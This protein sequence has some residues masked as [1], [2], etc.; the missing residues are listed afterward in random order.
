MK[1]EE[2]DDKKEMKKS[3]ATAA[4]EKEPLLSSGSLPRNR[5]PRAQLKPELDKGKSI[6]RDFTPEND[7]EYEDD[8]KSNTDVQQ[9]YREPLDPTSKKTS[10]T[11]R[12]EHSM[13]S[14]EERSRSPN[15]VEQIEQDLAIDE[16]YQKKSQRKR[17]ALTRKDI[18]YQ[19]LVKMQQQ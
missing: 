6:Y 19:E 18:Q 9:Q 10:N 13:N 2:E 14:H 8:N 16:V 3:D 11:H 1:L 7:T 17:Q 5:A 4:K 15:E 12:D